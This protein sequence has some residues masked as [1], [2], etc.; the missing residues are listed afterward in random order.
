MSLPII[1]SLVGGL[2][3]ASSASRAARAQEQ[4]AQDQVAFARE[5]RDLTREDMQP[6]YR[7]GVEAQNALASIYGIG[8][9]PTEAGEVVRYQMTPAQSGTRL[10][11]VQATV[12][13]PYDQG[14]TRV[15]Y[16]TPATYGY[17]VGDQT[18]TDEGQAQAYANSLAGPGYQSPVKAP[19][20]LTLDDFE[21]SPGYQFRLDQGM[22]AAQAGSAQR[23]GLNSGATQQALVD[24]GQGMASNEYGNFYNRSVN[25]FNALTGGLRSLA[26]GGQ[27]AAAG[28][29]AANAQAG[30]Q[31]INALGN[32]GNAS[33][34]G[35][36]GVSN[37][38][39]QGIG[40]AIGA[41]QYNQLLNSA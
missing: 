21:A 11:P 22:Q 26:Q 5:T 37:A 14:Y 13:R 2:F 4:A 32:M 17:R 29:G 41:W 20:D 27:N 8:G 12:G 35:S 23:F 15:S 39:N 25:N 40:N 19:W 16:D 3:G 7:S 28:M 36:I 18:F 6:F 33:A 9:G 30:A 10:E 24:Y 34:A 38:L 1:G 31:T